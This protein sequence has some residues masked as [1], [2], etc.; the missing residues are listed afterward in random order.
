MLDKI[1]RSLKWTT[2]HTVFFGGGFV[3]SIFSGSLDGFYKAL[4]SGNIELV[5]PFILFLYGLSS[6]VAFFFIINGDNV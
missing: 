1:M 4:F 5:V 3:A 6:M 2:V